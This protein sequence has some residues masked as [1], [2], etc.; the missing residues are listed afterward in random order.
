MSRFILFINFL[1]LKFAIRTCSSYSKM[2]SCVLLQSC[3]HRR[4]ILTFGLR[5]FN[6]PSKTC[7]MCSPLR[8][9]DISIQAFQAKFSTCLNFE[10]LLMRLFSKLFSKTP[11]LSA[12]MQCSFQIPHNRKSAEEPESPFAPSSVQW[13]L[14]FIK[15]FIMKTTAVN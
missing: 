14:F 7:N 6:T 10:K 11:G 5:P 8:N 9:R 4:L 3:L 2:F 1:D 12:A 13:N 15:V